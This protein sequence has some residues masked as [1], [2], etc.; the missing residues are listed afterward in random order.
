MFRIDYEAL[1][2][3]YNDRYGTSFKCVTDVFI[4]AYQQTNKSGN[5]AADLLGIH[6]SIVYKRLKAAG[7][8]IQRPGG[9]TK[10]FLIEKIRAISNSQLKQ[11][12]ETELALYLGCSVQTVRNLKCK[13]GF[14]IKG[15]D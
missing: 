9:H 6:S 5:R 1:R 13:H 11:L 10:P 2:R 12:S 8:N 4:D 15:R 14:E 7:F 3:G